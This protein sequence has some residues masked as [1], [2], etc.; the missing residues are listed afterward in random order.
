MYLGSEFV[1]LL[2]PMVACCLFC[3]PC[4]TDFPRIIQVTDC[5]Q[6]CN[7]YDCGVYVLLFAEYLA[8][9]L[10]LYTPFNDQLKP[11]DLSN[12]CKD[13]SFIITASVADSFRLKVY[14]EIVQFYEA[15][16][17]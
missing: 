15:A 17:H 3:I 4:R 5:P 2:I 13:T 10:T 7:G 11:K 16:R 14:S 1:T 12:F 6:Q 9:Q 8:N